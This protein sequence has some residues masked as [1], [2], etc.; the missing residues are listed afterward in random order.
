MPVI[1]TD[2]NEVTGSRL[3]SIQEA[4]VII[5][6]RGDDSIP[7]HMVRLLETYLDKKIM[8]LT[9][10]EI[11]QPADDNLIRAMKG[12][13]VSRYTKDILTRPRNYSLVRANDLI[14]IALLLNFDRLK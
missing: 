13:Y 9:V 10:S 3:T 6:E 11:L 8:P 12:K 14:Y 5:V 4:K 7:G 2:L 1:G